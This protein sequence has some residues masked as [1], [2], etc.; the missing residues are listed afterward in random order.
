MDRFAQAFFDA[1]ECGVELIAVG[2]T[3][4]TYSSELKVVSCGTA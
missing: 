1:T 4:D 3:E 2:L